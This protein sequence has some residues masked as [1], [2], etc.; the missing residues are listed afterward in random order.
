[1][2]KSEHTSS[3]SSKRQVKAAGKVIAARN[4]DRTKEVIDAF[5]VAHTWRDSFAYP[6]SRIHYELSAKS[7]QFGEEV[8]TAAR[9]KRMQSIRRK[10][11]NKAET[12]YQLQDIAGCRVVLPSER[13]VDALVS[14]YHEAALHRLVRENDYIAEP[15]R[16]GYRSHHL[17]FKYKA[18]ADWDRVYER[19]FIEVQIRSRLQHS[20]ATAVE[21]VGLFTGD[22]LKWQE[23]SQIWLRFFE[24]MSA[25]FAVAEKR[26]IGPTVSENTR[27]RRKEL[28][29]LSRE[30]NAAETLDGYNH[31]ISYASVPGVRFSRYC[32]LRFDLEER[33]VTVWPYHDDFDESS[34]AY[35][36]AEKNGQVN[37]VLV[38]VQKAKSLEAAFPNYFLDVSDFV[39]HLRRIL[40]GN[41]A[42]LT[43]AFKGVPLNLE[44]WKNRPVN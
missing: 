44:F 38:E 10:L 29:D 8:I 43:P 7:R 5:L 12:L 15:K 17:I 22:H 25:E 21:A 39:R 33:V 23:G 20:W 19:Q 14:L 1:M 9:L 36:E 34:K 4:T 16:D 41:T 13:D 30:L 28:R 2:A 37:T 3:D 26:P 32:I 24:L 27:I 31:A 18:R 6:M 42:E 35:I 11:Q 40:D